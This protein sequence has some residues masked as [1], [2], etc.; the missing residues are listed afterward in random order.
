MEKK[1]YK[2]FLS[3]FLWMIIPSIYNVIRMGIIS[4]NQVDINILGQMEWFDLIDE[5]LVTALTVPLF[6][7]LKSSVTSKEKNGIAFIMAF[8]VYTIFALIVSKYV[9]NIS[10]FMNARFASE[11]LK[12]QTF[13]LLIGFI[14]TF[15]IVLLTL[16][17]DFRMV[18]ILTMVKLSMLS[19]LD[20]VF[21][22]FFL[23]L[24]ASYSEIITNSFIGIIALIIVY[25][26]KYIGFGKIN[27]D[28]LNDYL[29]IGLFSGLQIFLDNF[30]YAIMICKMV[31]AVSE[32]GNYW[33]ANN[34]IWGWLLIPVMVITEIIKKNNLERLK[35]KNTWKYGLLIS[36]LWL[37]SVPGWR[38]FIINVMFSDANIIL[39]IL[40]P[41]VPFYIAY[42]ISSFIDGWFISKGKTYYNTINSFLV[43]VVYYGIAFILFNKGLFEL[44]IMFV[45]LLFG[46]GNVFH[47]LIS[48]FLYKI[49]IRGKNSEFKSFKI[50][51]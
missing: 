38:W 20:F 18:V 17:N 41:L 26:R 51:N 5:I 24:G 45:I 13:S 44:N 39:N 47:M 32:S 11:Y 43:N 1:D 34:F 8:S 22:D 36:I 10:E 46:F 15:C 7:L 23:E 49:E 16:N 30:I 28:W 4:M 42:I 12:L 14:S 48:V 19:I 9:S 25:I 6:S 35:F 3:L 40:Y 2:L 29:K 21:I 27:L 33:V 31:N 37:V 50:S